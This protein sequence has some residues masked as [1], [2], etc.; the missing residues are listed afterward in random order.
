MVPTTPVETGQSSV[1]PALNAESSVCMIN[2]QTGCYLCTVA[3]LLKWSSGQI[4][5][6]VLTHL[7]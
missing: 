5:H 4:E 6:G 2:T 1:A 3:D 7:T